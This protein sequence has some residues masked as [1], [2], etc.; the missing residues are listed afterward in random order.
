MEKAFRLGL[1]NAVCAQDELDSCVETLVGRLL[2][3]GPEALKVCKKLLDDVAGMS[4]TEAKGHTARVIAEV[5]VS[6]E[7]QEGMS[8]FLEKRKPNWAEK[9]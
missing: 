3:S 4:L 2:S 7:G 1:V 5:R 8:A 6:E 9:R